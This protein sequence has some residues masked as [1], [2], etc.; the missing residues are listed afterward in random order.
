MVIPENE[1][2]PLEDKD[3]IGSFYDANDGRLVYCR[4]GHFREDVTDLPVLDELP[5]DQEKFKELITSS[6]FILSEQMTA[7][8]RDAFAKLEKEIEE[9]DGRVDSAD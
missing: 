7:V 8:F 2:K 4:N 5:T 3:L 1:R 9:A 6:D